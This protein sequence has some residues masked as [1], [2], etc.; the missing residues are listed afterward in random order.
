MNDAPSTTLS[1]TSFEPARQPG[2]RMQLLIQR[3]ILETTAYLHSQQLLAIILIWSSMGLTHDDIGVQAQ[4][5]LL[6]LH[7]LHLLQ[8]T[9]TIF[10]MLHFFFSLLVTWNKCCGQHFSERGGNVIKAFNDNS[11]FLSD[12]SHYEIFPANIHEN[13][14]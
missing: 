7:L 3:Q 5:H 14:S 4:R 6:H 2:R 1:T 8:S 9:S 11:Y 12:H 10:C 13:Q